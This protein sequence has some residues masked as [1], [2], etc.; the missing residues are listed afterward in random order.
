MISLGFLIKQSI[1]H[2]PKPHSFYLQ[3]SYSLIVF[4][5]VIIH[6]NDPDKN[7][8]CFK[9]CLQ[10]GVKI[11]I[12]STKYHGHC[13]LSLFTVYSGEMF[14]SCVEIYIEKQLKDSLS[15]SVNNIKT[16]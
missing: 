3:I 1:N 15:S 13:C 14:L 10:N 12:K 11:I 2:A 5:K 16:T 8:E 4:E 7:V 9:K 6:I